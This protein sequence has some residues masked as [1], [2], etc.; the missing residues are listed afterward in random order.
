MVDIWDL[1]SKNIIKIR[2][3]VQ[4]SSIH[5]LGFFFHPVSPFNALPV[6]GK[7]L[8]W[9]KYLRLAFWGSDTILPSFTDRA[10]PSL[11]YEFLN[12]RLIASIYGHYFNHSSQFWGLSSISACKEADKILERSWHV[13]VLIAN[14]IGLG[15]KSKTQHDIA[16]YHPSTHLTMHHP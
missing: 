8:F 7:V 14:H 10:H 3:L 12:N 15:S 13:Q 16:I 1:W 11:T 6:S 9:L 5:Y 4:N 2:E